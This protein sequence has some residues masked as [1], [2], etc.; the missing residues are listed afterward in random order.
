V[1]E[2]GGDAVRARQHHP[3]VRPQLADGAPRRSRLGRRFDRDRRGKQRFGAELPETPGEPGGG[4]ARRSSDQHALAEER[5]LVEPGDLLPQRHDLADDDD[6]GRAHAG[7]LRLAGDRAERSDER[8]LSGRRAVL[9]H[10][11][12]GRR[13][14]TVRLQGVGDLPEVTHRHQEDDRPVRVAERRVVQRRLAL[15]RIFMTRRDDERGVVRAMGDGNPRVRRRRDGGRDARYDLE[16]DA[17]RAKRLGLL[18]AA[19]EDERIA[20]FEPN[21][22]FAARPQANQHRRN[23]VLRHRVGAG[24]LADVDPLAPGRREGDDRRRRERIVDQDLRLGEKPRRLHGQQAGIA[25]SGADEGDDAAHGRIGGEDAH[26]RALP[27][28]N[29]CSSGE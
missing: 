5:P 20:A 21:D 11:D 9:D 3:L 8:A 2:E 6:R 28:R 13:R 26:R 10:G 16:G 27:R 25:R 14:A 12:G 15:G 1:R 23:L 24:A 18:A 19:P 29:P 22:A 4:L 7:R 17:A